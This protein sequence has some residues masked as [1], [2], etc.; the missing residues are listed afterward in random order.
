[1]AGD[2]VKCNHKWIQCKTEKNNILTKFYTDLLSYHCTTYK[3]SQLMT[4]FFPS[5]DLQGF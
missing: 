2:S 4:Y 5:T 1:M 3:W